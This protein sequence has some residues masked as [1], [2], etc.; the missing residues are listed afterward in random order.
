PLILSRHNFWV[1]SSIAKPLRLSAP[2]QDCV[3]RKSP[4]FESACC[5]FCDSLERNGQILT[6]ETGGYKSGTSTDG[7][8]HGKRAPQ[9]SQCVRLKAL[10]DWQRAHRPVFSGTIFWSGNFPAGGVGRF[11]VWLR[12]FYSSNRAFL[13]L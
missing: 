12:H 4:R 10:G 2:R 3:A 8:S 7:G 1:D 11:I 13:K 5:N 6:D 9:S